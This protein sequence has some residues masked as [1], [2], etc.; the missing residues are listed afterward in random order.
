MMSSF[1]QMQSPSGSGSLPSNTVANPRGDVKAITTRSGVAYDGPMILP[2]PSPLLKEVE[3]ETK[4][5][6]DK[7]QAT[8]S[9]S[10]AHIQPPVVQVSI[11]EPEVALKPNPKP[12]IPYPSRLDDQKLR[13]KANNQMLK[14]FQIFQRLHFDISFADALLHMPKFAST[15]K[16]L[17]TLADLGASINL[18][19]LSAWKKL[20]LPELTPTRMTLELANRSVAIPVGVAEDVFVKVGKFYFPADF[21]VVD[22]DVDPRVPLILGR[23]FLRTARALINVHGEELTLR[24]NDEAITFKVRHTS[25]YSYKYNDES[26]NRIDFIDVTCEEYAQEVLGFLDSSKSSNPTPS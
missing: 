19:P 17:L 11:S 14:F 3:R 10:I 12:S 4:E 7:V 13:E 25:R 22:Y 20:S 9:E 2:T 26:I 5:T 18:M 23:P 6:K 16:S 21:V 1:L 15:F 8:S 24:V